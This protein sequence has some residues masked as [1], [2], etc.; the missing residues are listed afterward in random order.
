MM[1]SRAEQI[2]SFS[3]DFTP[4]SIKV[5]IAN[6]KIIVVLKEENDHITIHFRDNFELLDIH[7]KNQKTGKYEHLYVTKIER[8]V[9][10]LTKIGPELENLILKYIR[11]ITYEELSKQNFW[12][13]FNTYTER[14]DY[15]D[16]KTNKWSTF[17]NDFVGRSIILPVQQMKDYVNENQNRIYHVFEHE[18]T[19]PIGAVFQRVTNFDKPLHFFITNESVNNILKEGQKFLHHFSE[20]HDSEEQMK[21]ER[22]YK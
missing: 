1:D 21:L 12:L 5:R 9:S 20:L 18:E 6:D 22:K 4:A 8:L 10:T 11:Q 19:E 16:K 13:Q 17:E 14:E 15:F 3:F 2:S 7:R